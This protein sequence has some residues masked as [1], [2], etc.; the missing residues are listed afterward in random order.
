[1]S[2]SNTTIFWLRRDLRLS[3]NHGLYKALKE[4]GNVQ[5]LFIFDRHILDKLEDKNDKRLI[6]IHNQ[7]ES[8]NKRLSEYGSS[9]LT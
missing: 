6:F 4:S 7:L 3:D 5:L 8:I 9:L 1:M 2:D